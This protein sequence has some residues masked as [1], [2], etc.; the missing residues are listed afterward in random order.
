[1]I[2]TIVTMLIL[3]L[4]DPPRPRPAAMVLDLKGRVELRPA[5]GVARPAKVVDRLYPGDRLA[6]PADGTAT[7][8]FL[9]VGAQERLAA[10]SRGDDRPR[11]LHAEVGRGR[12]A[13]AAAGGGA[14]DEGGPRGGTAT[15]ARRRRRTSEP[16]ASLPPPAI[17]PIERRHG[18][19]RSAGFR[20]AAD[21]GGQ[22]LPRQAAL[23][24]RPRTLA[25]R[26]DDPEHG[27]P[28]RQSRR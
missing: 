5:A 9:G 2:C 8:A 7:V 19:R 25:G 14:D 21:K 24:C 27:L 15:T 13:G 11:G 18:R 16:A 20:L 17:T 26:G 4:A 1:M 6:V 23:G 3:L 10:G 28:R 12:A 22:G